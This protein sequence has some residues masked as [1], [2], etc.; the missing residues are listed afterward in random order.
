[1][2]Y[3]MD[4]DTRRKCAHEQCS[5]VRFPSRMCT[6]VLTVR[7]RKKSRKWNYS[8]TVSTSHAR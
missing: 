5:S 8:A 1:M 7:T 4:I 2:E 6:A 3:I